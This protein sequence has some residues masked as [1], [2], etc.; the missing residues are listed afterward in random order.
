MSVQRIRCPECS[1]ELIYATFGAE[2]SYKTGSAFEHDCARRGEIEAG[3]AL[4]C[5]AL[6]AAVEQALRAQFPGRGLSK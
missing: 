3:D 1:Y 4:S 6:R 2:G 5:P